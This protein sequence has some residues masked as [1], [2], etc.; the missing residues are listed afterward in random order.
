MTARPEAAPA[1]GAPGHNPDLV[2]F[3]GIA[4][5][6]E[7]WLV[8]LDIDGTLL[9]YEGGMA[10]AVRD[11]VIAASNAGHHIV[12]AS[13]R[14]LVSMLPLAA[15]LG[16]AD[17]RMVCSNGG[18]I[19]QVDP[20]LDAGYLIEQLRA[21]NPEPV[22]RELV[23]LLPNAR[24]AVEDVGRGWRLTEMFNDGELAGVFSVV[25]FDQ[26]WTGGSVTRV[27]V[28]GGD[29][30]PEEFSQAIADL[31]LTGASYFVGYNAWL[32]IT[33]RGVSKASALETVRVSLGVPPER[34]LAIGDGMNDIDMLEWAARGIAMGHA[35]LE[36][37]LAADEVTAPVT[38]DGVAA[39]LRPLL[40]T[41]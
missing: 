30:T 7:P 33:P 40:P 13:G 2:E 17:A 9:D 41:R 10:P 27:V 8:A 38:K 31:G 32:D 39:A 26:L 37:R 21:F 6:V 4:A 36:V 15:E 16:L 23:K 22:L 20:S 28:R 24:F 14:D 3:A 19:V 34:T 11:A 1:P 29:E 35:P 12:L 5:P 25:P 18:V